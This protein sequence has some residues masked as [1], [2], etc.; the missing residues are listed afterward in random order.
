MIW[1]LIGIYLRQA[2]RAGRLGLV[3]VV[4]CLANMVLQSGS[5]FTDQPPSPAN[6]IHSRPAWKTLG[7][8]NLTASR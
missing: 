5:M 6:R 1:G 7:D 2:D 8:P 3:A 4:A